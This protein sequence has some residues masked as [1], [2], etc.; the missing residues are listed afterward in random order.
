MGNARY[1]VLTVVSAVSMLA[2]L[3]TAMVYAPVE[4]SM[5]VVQKIF[6]FH[7]PSAYAMYLSWAVCAVS[8]ILYLA[9]R[10]DKWD[11]LAKSAAELA[12]LF[13]VVVMVTGPLWGRRAW[14]VFWSWDP[15]LTASL[16]FALII[17]SY[18]LLRALASGEAERR[19]AAALAILGA[20]M[21]PVIHIS[22]QKW[23]GQHPVL[24][25]GGLA[26]RMTVALVVSMVAFTLFFSLLLVSR[27]RLEKAR[28]RLDRM[29][30]RA[31]DMG[32][33]GEDEL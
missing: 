10:A 31:M 3:F 22:V 19:F 8:S 20:G 27:Y 30:E 16:L 17:L 32:L 13:A 1:I 26:P 33:L 29:T 23:R 28:R 7:V 21:V 5:G 14:G 18:V 11:M 15:R 9:R 25:R 24:D 2:A 6:Y 12:L 4:S